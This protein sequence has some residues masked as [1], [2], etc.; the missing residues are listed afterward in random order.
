MLKEIWKKLYKHQSKHE[1]ESLGATSESTGVPISTIAYHNKRR[2]KRAATSG[3]DYWDTDEG[4]LFLK[5]MII[6]LIYTFVIKGGIG[7]G[8][9]REHL[10]QLRLSG[11]MAVSESSLYRMIE[12]ICAVILRYKE[13]VEKALQKEAGEEL[14]HLKVV[15]G[16][17]ETWLDQMLLVC[18][19]LSSNYIFLR[20]QAKNEMQ[21]V[22][23][24]Q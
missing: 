18:Q 8:R 3:T 4:Q 9:V 21:S 5:R 10:T 13:L 19:D 20:S 14:K 7:A 11:V 2:E 1:G 22:G 24:D 12:E 23:G 16:I 15:L 6:S 17:A